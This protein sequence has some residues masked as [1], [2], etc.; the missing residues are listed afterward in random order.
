MPMGEACGRAAGMAAARGC[1]LREVSVEELRQVLAD[2]GTAVGD[3]HAPPG[4]G[5]G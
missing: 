4:G 3:R 5:A 2:A 1:S